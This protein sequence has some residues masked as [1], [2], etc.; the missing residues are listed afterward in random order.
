M[1]SD[2][3]SQ[4]FVSAFFVALALAPRIASAQ[5]LAGGIDPATGLTQIGSWMLTLVGIGIPIICAVKGAHAVAEGRHLMP[6]V[7][8]A[9]G[10]S[11]L[12]FGGSYI[13]SN[14]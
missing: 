7:G 11:A 13:I 9:V 1:K 12:A 2:K 10:G 4:F 6:Y 5:A 3:L 8:S 14:Y